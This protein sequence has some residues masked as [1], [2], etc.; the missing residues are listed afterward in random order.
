[1]EYNTGRFIAGD[2]E[3]GCLY[4]QTKSLGQIEA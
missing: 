1:M 2:Q 4:S 3:S